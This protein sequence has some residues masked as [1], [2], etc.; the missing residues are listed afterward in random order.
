MENAYV[1]LYSDNNTTNISYIASI[2]V[3]MSDNITLSEIE[4]KNSH[5][6][7]SSPAGTVMAGSL[8]GYAKG[9]SKTEVTNSV[10]EANID[11]TGT[12][13]ETFAGNLL[14]KGENL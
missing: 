1:K 12:P 3:A 14:L 13:T 2:L 4:I 7:V 6:I 8:I 5:L 9:S 10:V 11:I